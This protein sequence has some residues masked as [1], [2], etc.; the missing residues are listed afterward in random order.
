MSEARGQVPEA[1]QAAAYVSGRAAV[2][3]PSSAVQL[4]PA[5]ESA[6]AEA[7]AQ[8]V[9]TLEAAIRAAAAATADV[10]TATAGTF[11]AQAAAA[12][13]A[14]LTAAA[15]AAERARR[16][17]FAA[18]QGAWIDDGQHYVE[19]PEVN[20]MDALPEEEPEE[21]RVYEP[22]PLMTDSDVWEP[23]EQSVLA[24]LA[25]AGGAAAAPGGPAAAP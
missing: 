4:P 22:K 8:A 3:G 17:A 25:A 13:Q 14:A 16:E 5:E 21:A 18:A 6:R 9:A 20:D 2:G 19:D 10:A 15:A 1:A 7:A 12:T 23:F 11:A 24:D